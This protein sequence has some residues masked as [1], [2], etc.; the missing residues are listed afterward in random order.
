MGNMLRFQSRSGFY[1]EQNPWFCKAFYLCK[2]TL[3][4]IYLHKVADRV[5][6]TKVVVANPAGVEMV[7]TTSHYDIP[8]V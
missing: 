1:L 2:L 4:K 6:A 7:D 3:F 8:S 5:L